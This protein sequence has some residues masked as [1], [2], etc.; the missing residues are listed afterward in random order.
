M[1]WWGWAVLFAVWAGMAAF[2]WPNETLPGSNLG[3]EWRE[4]SVWTPLKTLVIYALLAAASA[5]IA[6]NLER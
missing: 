3:I 5:V 4:R 6:L 2:M 1:S